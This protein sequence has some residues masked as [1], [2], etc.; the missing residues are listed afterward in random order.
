[1]HSLM[2]PVLQTRSRKD[3]RMPG[4]T[5]G[6]IHDKVCSD[7]LQNYWSLTSEE[8]GFLVRTIYNSIDSMSSQQRHQWNVC[9]VRVCFSRFCAIVGSSQTTLRNLVS[10]IPALPKS[11]NR[12]KVAEQMAKCHLFFQ[13]LHQ[14]AAVPDPDQDEGTRVSS[15]SVVKSKA[16]RKTAPGDSAGFWQA[17]NCPLLFVHGC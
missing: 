5:P 2:I 14:S 11:R 12:T 7:F 6:A 4:C 8:R 10:G 9:G 15:A 3:C 1:M 16:A 17:T 13:Q